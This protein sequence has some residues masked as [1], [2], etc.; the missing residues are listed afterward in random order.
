VGACTTLIRRRAAR[1]QR[2]IKPIHATLLLLGIYEDTGSLT[3]TGTTPRDVRAAAFLLDQG[4]SLQILS[5]YLNP[6]LS[7]EQR[8][9]LRPA[10]L[11]AHRHNPR[12]EFWWR[13]PTPK[14]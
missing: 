11:H 13:A 8:D 9:G 5:R 3:Y 14:N 12:A 2:R 7:D 10:A 6:P 1:A 4:A